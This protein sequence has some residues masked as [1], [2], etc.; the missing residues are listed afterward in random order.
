VSSDSKPDY[1]NLV[2]HVETLLGEMGRRYFSDPRKEVRALNEFM[3]LGKSAEEIL[4]LVKKLVLIR[5]EHRENPKFK[6]DVFWM[7]ATENIAGALSYW[8]KIESVYEA[9][10]PNNNIAVTIQKKNKDEIEEKNLATFFQFCK[11][12]PESTRIEIERAEI[13]EV[14]NKKLSVKGSDKAWQYVGLYFRSTEWILERV[15]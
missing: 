9:L 8:Q 7:N 15:I 6:S 12:I 1:L 14:E 3:M 13:S 10:F 4:I 2:S 5:K 11:S